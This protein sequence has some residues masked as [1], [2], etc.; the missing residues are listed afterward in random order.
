MVEVIDKII[1]LDIDGVLNNKDLHRGEYDKS[2]YYSMHQ[3]NLKALKKLLR[4]TNATIVLSSA[5]R[6]SKESR[7][8]VKKFF[9]QNNIPLFVSITPR[10][11]SRLG[12]ILLWLKV[13]TTNVDLGGGD[14]AAINDENNN[15]SLWKLPKKVKV[16][17]WVILDDINFKKHGSDVEY[18][19]LPGVGD[20]VVHTKR[21]YGLG[22]E[23][24][25]LAIEK[26]TTANPCSNCEL[27]SHWGDE[28]L[29]KTFCGKECQKCYYE[30][31]QLVMLYSHQ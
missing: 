30:T 6:N 27:K 25:A 9:R 26:L 21:I 1:F 3:S 15:E 2:A 13:N 12:E 18:Y 17:R 28:V 7:D 11:G 10:T 8:Q 14:D 22:Y 19:N 29:N 4:A 5:W 24:V 23:E 20:H 16:N 31:H